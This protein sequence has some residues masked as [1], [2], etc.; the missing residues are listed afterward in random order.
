MEDLFPTTTYE[1]TT[2]A[3]DTTL[4][5]L[6]TAKEEGNAFISSEELDK[7]PTPEATDPD[8]I[9][10]LDQMVAKFQG[11][12]IPS[13][14]EQPLSLGPTESEPSL[15]TESE[16]PLTMDTTESEQPL[17][18]S[19]EPLTTDTTEPDPFEPM[20]KALEEE[21]KKELLRQ[22]VELDE[23]IPLV[24]SPDDSEEEPQEQPTEEVVAEEEPAKEEAIPPTFETLSEETVANEETPAN[25]ENLSLDPLPEVPNVTE[26][27]AE[28]T[29]EPTAET[30]TEEV[31]A[32]QSVL[33]LDDIMNETVAP[34]PAPTATT[35]ET[36]KTGLP[37]AKFKKA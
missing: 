17:E 18:T 31:P 22:G 1:P 7:Q 30:T 21:E 16:Q 33:S 14:P 2:E 23:N 12:E 15:S 20:K 37:F 5:A 36:G 24:I 4:Q 10:N 3:F 28:N 6:T 32:P 9:L 35:G 27:V 19:E 13:E 26:T 29:T 8:K 34:A 25:T 11:D